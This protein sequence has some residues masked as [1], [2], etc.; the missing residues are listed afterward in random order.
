MDR[1]QFGWHH[2][3]A[4]YYTRLIEKALAIP[5]WMPRPR[6]LPMALPGSGLMPA[7]EASAATAQVIEGRSLSAQGFGQ[8]VANA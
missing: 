8:T 5:L 3:L 4:A 6:L 7:A 2:Q 1:L